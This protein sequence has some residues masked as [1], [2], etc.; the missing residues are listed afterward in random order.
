MG[1]QIL[2]NKYQVTIAAEM[3]GKRFE[4]VGL[5]EINGQ[6]PTIEVSIFAN[7]DASSQAD[8]SMRF[9]PQEVV[10]IVTSALARP[11]VAGVL[12]SALRMI[13]N[14]SKPIDTKKGGTDGGEK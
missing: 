7:V 6:A 4:M 9:T 10:D 12:S 2:S 11:E 8:A 5:K 3:D 1:I 14:I 13:L